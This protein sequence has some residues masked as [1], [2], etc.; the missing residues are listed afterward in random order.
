MP[1]A[2]HVLV[3]P[4]ILLAGCVTTEVEPKQREAI[5]PEILAEHESR[6]VKQFQA[7]NTIVCRTLEI[8]AN[9]FVFNNNVTL[10]VGQPRRERNDLFEQLTWSVGDQISMRER[11]EAKPGWD[12]KPR[13][14]TRKRH[15]NDKFRIMIGTT[16]FIVDDRITVRRLFRAPPTL[17]AH[18]KGHVMVIQN[19]KEASK[20]QEVRFSG[21]QV[22]AR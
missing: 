16:T 20:Y 14:V 8:E 6:L 21:G 11:M 13:K 12:S 9:L 19:G 17:T 5:A 10:P 15:V 7:D 18:A 2:R 1:I 22:E 3:V 4:A